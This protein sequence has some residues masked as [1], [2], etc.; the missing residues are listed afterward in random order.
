M[1]LNE[2]A[3]ELRKMA[4]E[5]DAICK[6]SDIMSGELMAFKYCKEHDLMYIED[7]VKGAFKA[8][9]MTCLRQHKADFEKEGRK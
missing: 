8:G 6:D 9:W 1:T 2:V 4:D 5:M 7:E 3:G